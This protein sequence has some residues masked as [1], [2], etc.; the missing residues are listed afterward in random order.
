MEDALKR[1]SFCN[2]FLQLMIHNINLKIFV[3]NQNL[4]RP[5]RHKDHF[6]I[7]EVYFLDKKDIKDIK[8]IKD[9]SI[10]KRTISK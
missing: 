7:G 3:L 9:K 2:K 10:K 1:E 8:D 6:M 5:N 4:S